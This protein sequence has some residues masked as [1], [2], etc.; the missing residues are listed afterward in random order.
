MDMENLVCGVI[1]IA[2]LIALTV[3]PTA[4]KEIIGL[5]IAAILLIKLL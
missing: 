5:A 2:A 1:A 3:I 4:S